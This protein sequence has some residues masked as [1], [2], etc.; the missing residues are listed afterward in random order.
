M[1]MAA[2]ANVRSKRLCYMCLVFTALLQ[3]EIIYSNVF[4]PALQTL[5]FENDFLCREGSAKLNRPLVKFLKHGYHCLAVNIESQIIISCG[6]ISINPGPNQS[7]SCFMQN[8]RSLKA[9]RAV[10]GS[11][12]SKL[13]L[14]QDTV[15]GHDFDIICLTETWL[16]DS[17]NDYEILP[18][19]YN[20]FR[21]D[22]VG[23]IGGGTLTAIKTSLSSSE[24]VKP[25]EFS[26]LEVNLV[27]ISKLKYDRSILVVN[28]YRPPNSTEFVTKFF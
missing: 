27:E 20:I 24:I 4:L 6:D 23:R 1:V 10:E 14:L 9:F 22:R 17:I 13:G 18:T 15:Y 2:A 21:H 25:A 8:V 11:F 3:Q 19:G 26:D 16:N 5:G 7:L 12:E 28:A